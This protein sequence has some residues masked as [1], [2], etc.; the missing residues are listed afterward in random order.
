V[1][2]LGH[3]NCGAVEA[4]IDSLNA[5]DSDHTNNLA[6][7]VDRVRPAV[8]PLIQKDPDQSREELVKKSVLANVH[9]SV[10]QL[11]HGSALIENLVKQGKLTIV[12]A[13]YSL[14]RGEVDF[15]EGVPEDA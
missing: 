10:A 3:S 4:T 1:V 14:G 15:F 8:E 12:G 11:Q 7:I 9:Q 5:P 13:K 2:L 6:A